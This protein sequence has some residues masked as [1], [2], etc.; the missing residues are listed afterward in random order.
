MREGD[1]S[2]G[3]RRGIGDGTETDGESEGPRLRGVRK[4]G[5]E[6][7]NKTGE[8]G[9]KVERSYMLRMRGCAR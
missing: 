7:G 4:M 6:V 3:K 2:G 8:G 5:V 9:G 1:E